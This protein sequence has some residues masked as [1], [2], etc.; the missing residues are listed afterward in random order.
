MPLLTHSDH[1][2]ET[3]PFPPGKC[4][5]DFID[6]ADFTGLPNAAGLADSPAGLALEVK[7]LVGRAISALRQMWRGNLTDEL[8]TSGGGRSASSRSSCSLSPL[9][10][11][12]RLHCQ[13]VLA[14]VGARVCYMARLRP[15]GLPRGR[16]ALEVQQG[17]TLPSGSRA[18]PSSVD[19]RRGDIWP[20]VIDDISL[21]PEGTVPTSIMAWSPQCKHYLEEFR[22]RMLRPPGE[23]AALHQQQLLDQIEPYVDPSIQKDMLRLA[24]RMAKSGMLAGVRTRQATV[25]LFIVVKKVQYDNS[26]RHIALRLVFDE[27]VPNQVWLP[28]P[29]MGLAGAGALSALDVSHLRRADCPEASEPHLALATGDLPNYYFHLLLPLELAEWFA[30]PGIELG[31]LVESLRKSGFHET[32]DRMWAEGGHCA[33][34]GVGVRVPVMG[35]N[36]AVFLA[37]SFLVDLLLQIPRTFPSSP[38]AHAISRERLLMEGAPPPRLSF[39][40]PFFW[41]VYIDDFAVGRVAWGPAELEEVRELKRMIVIQCRLAGFDVHKDD[42]GIQVTTIGHTLGGAIPLIHGSPEKL[43]LA[44]ECLWYLG[45]HG[46]ATAA[47]V[48]SV[49]SLATWLL[50]VK[51]AALSILESTYRWV[52]AHRD[53]HQARALPKKVRRELV[54][55]SAVL[56]LAQQDLR[57]E[58]CPVVMMMDAAGGDICGGGECYTFATTEELQSEAQWAVRG[59]W[60]TFTGSND[61]VEMWRQAQPRPACSPTPTL[62]KTYLVIVLC[63]GAKSDFDLS[64]KLI[65]HGATYGWRIWIVNF[66]RR[67]GDDFDLTREDVARRLFKFI[68]D[69]RPDG[70]LFMPPSSSWRLS[71]KQGQRWI[72]MRTSH[73]PW[74]LH[75]LGSQAKS[76]VESQSIVMRVG[77]MA[78][79]RAL[80]N[81]AA[82]VCLLP[83][84]RGD[85]IWSGA[86]IRDTAY[87]RSLEHLSDVAV[88]AMTA[89]PEGRSAWHEVESWSWLSSADR[90]HPR[91]LPRGVRRRRQR[92]PEAW[93]GALVDEF[94]Q[95]FRHREPARSRE[96]PPSSNSSDFE[97]SPGDRVPVPPVGLCWD[98]LSRWTEVARYTWRIQEHNNVLEGRAALSSVVRLAQRGNILGKRCVLMT[99]SQVVLGAFSKGRSSRPSLNLLAR[100]LGALILGY[101]LKL[102]WRYVPT[103]RN[104]ADAPSR[105]L[106]WGLQADDSHHLGDLMASWTLWASACANYGDWFRRSAP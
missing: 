35:W 46:R 91:N 59:G 85:S 8:L 70:L 72:P 4:A 87:F 28:P 42:L 80:Q 83:D 24:A 18:V 69:E 21:P 58:W 99:D 7:I 12:M 66:D 62:E 13:A 33:S 1:T 79:E 6:E 40:E 102:Y 31:D 26:R 29:W 101:S 104:F 11:E 98:S 105:G 78:A 20:A 82:V 64:C 81:D 106:P 67:R 47:Q 63:L 61:F 73:E 41:Y 55:L 50:M 103:H 53:C 37:Q 32:A 17:R 16:A 3:S 51:R 88:D 89:K 96:D 92:L 38:L 15:G 52:R 100:R 90:G 27:R 48:E 57:S 54:A 95:V 84:G 76:L 10:A 86:R 19:P 94:L 65:P 97:G 14:S 9:S 22:S 5:L 34:S 56:P 45:T 60:T 30:L 74:G 23:V 77:L 43:W 39:S 2:M 36:W 49:I 68:D 93:H 44:V 75:R 25:G 71:T